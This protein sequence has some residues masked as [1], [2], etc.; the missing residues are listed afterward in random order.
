MS[1]VGKDLTPQHGTHRI[2]IP[3]HWH[4]QILF[5]TAGKPSKTVRSPTGQSAGAGP[6]EKIVR[7]P[8]GT[9]PISRRMLRQTQRALRTA[10][11][12]HGPHLQITG[13]KFH[14]P[15]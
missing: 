2:Q 7:S 13:K 8:T 4:T 15:P 9:T 5:A 1:A 14:P 3:D 6:G 12:G 10:L 11:E